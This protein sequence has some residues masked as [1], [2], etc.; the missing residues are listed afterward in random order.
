MLYEDVL[1]HKLQVGK[2]RV[3]LVREWGM[4]LDTMRLLYL[5]FPGYQMGRARFEHICRLLPPF[6]DAAHHL[7]EVTSI[8]DLGALFPC[9][10][11]HAIQA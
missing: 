8:L 11:C 10:R 7:L 1:L 3:R 2:C 4:A 5:S 6:T 9:C